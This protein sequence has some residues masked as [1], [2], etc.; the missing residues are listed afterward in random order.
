MSDTTPNAK[1]TGRK[2]A[3]RKPAARKPKATLKSTFS[4]AVSSGLDDTVAAIRES[5]S[6]RAIEVGPKVLEIASQKAATAGAAMVAWGKKHPVK[7]AAA[8]AALLLAA[9]LMQTAMKKYAA[10]P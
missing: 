4:D 3:S 9:K 5:A 6:E 7:T 2:T 1:S 8:A 10:K